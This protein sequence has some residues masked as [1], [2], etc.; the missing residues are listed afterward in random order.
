MPKDID[1]PAPTG[2]PVLNVTPEMIMAGME[3]YLDHCPDTGLGDVLD[4]EMVRKILT[5]AM[6]CGA[7]LNTNHPPDA[8]QQMYEHTHRL[9]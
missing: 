5:A 8:E 7:P 9:P 2:P 4:Q 1:S 3:V 6:S